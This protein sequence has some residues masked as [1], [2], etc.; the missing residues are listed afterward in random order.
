MDT[1]LGLRAFGAAVLSAL[2]STGT[3]LHHTLR[4]PSARETAAAA[5]SDATVGIPLPVLV[6][7]AVE[8]WRLDR[9]LA[10]HGQ[11]QTTAAARF[12]SRRIADALSG[13]ELEAIDLTG[14]AY[15]PGLA[16][17]LLGTV[18]DG[19]LPAGTVLID[20]MVAPLC[21]WQ[22]RVVRQG[23]VITRSSTR[24]ASDGGEA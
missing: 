18:D 22:G 8:A 2:R 10:R 6:D 4:G 17:E 9:W 7:L 5:G 19:A 12:A 15:D 3:A 23:Q 20:E 24:G 13:L 1:P 11:D 16:L 14:Q 21:L